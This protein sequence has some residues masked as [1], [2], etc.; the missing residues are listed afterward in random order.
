MLKLMPKLVDSSQLIVHRNAT[1]VNRE[2]KTV[3]CRLWRQGFTLIELLIVVPII[4]ILSSFAIYS[5][6]TAQQK[7]RDAARKSDLAQVK[8][9]LETVKADCTGSA[10]YP[11]FFSV[12][13]IT[14][15]ENN[16]DIGLAIYLSN[17]NLKYIPG[18]IKDP[19]NVSPQKYSY[20]TST[21]TATKCP[22]TSG[23]TAQNGATDFALAVKLERTDDA[24]ATNSRTK[25]TGTGKPGDAAPPTGW[26]GAGYY[27]VCNS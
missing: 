26:N 3:N 14:D 11:S 23:G 19:K 8:K 1:T 20:Y 6:S 27:V 7:A 12:L 9:A 18:I 24:D 22:D 21:S 5:F 13:S 25:C 15:A 4:G 17:T 10:Y 2:L 16:Y